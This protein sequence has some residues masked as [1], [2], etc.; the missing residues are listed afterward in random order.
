[1]VCYDGSDVKTHTVKP[2]THLRGR[3]R[4]FLAPPAPAER[5]VSRT[6]Y[7]EVGTEYR[8]LLVI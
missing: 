4:R 3:F 2:D 8:R 5:D 6:R 7:E 1:M